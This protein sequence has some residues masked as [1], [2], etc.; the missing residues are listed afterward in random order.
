MGFRVVGVDR[1]TGKTLAPYDTRA[2]SESTA[3]A[4]A[5]RLGVS[6]VALTPIA[7]D[8]ADPM[9]SK[10]TTLANWSAHPLHWRPTAWTLARL[11]FEHPRWGKWLT[12]PLAVSVGIIRAKV[13]FKWLMM[14]VVTAL[15]GVGIEADPVLVMLT[16][17]PVLIL[18][19][20]LAVKPFVFTRLRRE[21]AQAG[22]DIEHLLH[23]GPER[24][25]YYDGERERT[26]QVTAIAAV[27]ELRHFVLLVTRD[28]R[29]IAVPRTSF[30]SPARGFAF[31]RALSEAAG[32]QPDL[33]D[34]EAAERARKPKPRAS[35]A[36]VACLLLIPLVVI[37]VLLFD[38]NL[39]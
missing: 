2:E 25:R 6:I 31:V 39:R 14:S 13:L 36:F 22:F 27:H 12:W 35:K 9:F 34:R 7:V 19:P 33:S 29:E 24:L 20:L 28:R 10:A 38:I 4:E 32:V 15:A 23:V 21:H 37:L 18:G 5:A 1:E 17:I 30:L 11:G 16:L 26:V 3:H 8:A